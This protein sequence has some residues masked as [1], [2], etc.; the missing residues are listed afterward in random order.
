MAQLSFCLEVHQP[1]RLKRYRVFDIGN[2]QEYFVDDE[3][4]ESNKVLFQKLSEDL[5][6]PMC[7]VLHGMLDLNP[8]F[9]MALSLSG[10]FLEQAEEYAPEMLDAFAF[11]V[12]TGQV[13]LVAQTY[14]QSL[15]SIYSEKEFRQQLLLHSQA[16]QGVFGVTPTTLY[17]RENFPGQKIRQSISSLGYTAMMLG[18]PSIEDQVDEGTVFYRDGL[19]C[20]PPHRQISREYVNAALDGG[21]QHSAR[22]LAQ[23]VAL[24]GTD[25]DVISVMAPLGFMSDYH[26]LTNDAAG[27]LRAL[28]GEVAAAGGIFVLPSEIAP[29]HTEVA[30]ELSEDRLPAWLSN[31]MQ[32][33]AIVS[34]Y[35]LEPKIVESG[36][37]QLIM[38]WRRLQ[39]SDHFLYMDNNHRH[40][41]PYDTHYD[42]F[43][44]FNNV[45]ADLQKRLQ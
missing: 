13:E 14:H 18:V 26:S 9:K 3:N 2:D 31:E 30:V 11:L 19:V 24:A 45:L 1:R 21:K 44:N 43:I 7:L 40:I 38:D 8:D 6:M 10:M 42:A 39:S 35:N 41:S 5:Y 29:A 17:Q 27:F 12:E 25:E 32:H 28:P 15:A 33:E 20:I 23:L 36:D 34:L 4:T 16:L 37:E 22:N